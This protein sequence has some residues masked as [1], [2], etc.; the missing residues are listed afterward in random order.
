MRAF[1]AILREERE[2]LPNIAPTLQ[3]LGEEVAA[4]QAATDKFGRA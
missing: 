4:G 3:A 2:A 1:A